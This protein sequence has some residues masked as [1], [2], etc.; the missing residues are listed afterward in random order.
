VLRSLALEQLARVA[1]S[2]LVQHEPVLEQVGMHLDIQE[3]AYGAFSSDLTTDR[4]VDKRADMYFW[5]WWPDYNDA[6]DYSWI[7]FNSDAAPDKCACYN[8]G[9]YKNADVDKIINDGFT[10]SDQAKLDSSFKEAQRIMGQDVDP[11]I[12]PTSQRIMGQDVDPPII[13]TGQPIDTTYYRID[14]DGQVSN[15]LYIFTWD[16]Y[17]LHRG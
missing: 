5:G 10:E 1:I 17:A 13:P 11:P 15:P 12:I 16:F 7:L 9:Y 14:I 8:S 4:P 2:A 6:S 3:K